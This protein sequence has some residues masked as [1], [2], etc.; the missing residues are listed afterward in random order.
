MK[1]IP[2][3]VQLQRARLLKPGTAVQVQ[4]DTGIVH[5]A[6]VQ[7]YP[8]LLGGHTYVVNCLGKQR[9]FRAYSVMRVTPSGSEVAA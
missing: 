8:W 9:L 6:H 1:P 3:K 4:D 5:A 7:D 2:R